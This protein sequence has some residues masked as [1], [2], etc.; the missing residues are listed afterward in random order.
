MLTPLPLA[1]AT[2]SV[3]LATQT[4]TAR[5]SRIGGAA[6]AAKL[7]ERLRQTIIERHVG[8]PGA[9]PGCGSGNVPRREGNCDI[10]QYGTGRL[11]SRGQYTNLGRTGSSALAGNRSRGRKAT[12]KTP[13][14]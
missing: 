3:I 13:W 4:R 1:L 8:L 2:T 6:T 10:N 9:S 11:S 14:Q 12:N 5:R 7:L